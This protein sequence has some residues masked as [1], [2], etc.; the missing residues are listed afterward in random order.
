MSK[1]SNSAQYGTP[2]PAPLLRIHGAGLRYNVPGAQ[3]P[4]FGSSVE[5]VKSKKMESPKS[6]NKRPEKS[7]AGSRIDV[8]A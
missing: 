8:T 6:Q 3:K 4:K 7:G 2:I 5:T 1:V